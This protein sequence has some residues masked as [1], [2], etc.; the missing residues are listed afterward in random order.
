M[1]VHKKAA[2]KV[3]VKLATGRSCTQLF[4]ACKC[5]KKVVTIVQ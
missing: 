2:R 5:E 4:Q 3:L 1:S